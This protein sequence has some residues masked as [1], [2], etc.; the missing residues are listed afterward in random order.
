MLQECNY[1]PNSYPQSRMTSQTCDSLHPFSA[2]FLCRRVPRLLR[3]VP[4]G[5]CCLLR[6]A[7]N[8]ALETWAELIGSTLEDRRQLPWRP[9]PG[10]CCGHS[11]RPSPLPETLCGYSWNTLKVHRVVEI[12]GNA[13]LGLKTRCGAEI[14]RNK[15][16]VSPGRRYRD[17]QKR[18][19]GTPGQREHVARN[20]LRGFLKARCR[21]PLK[22][23]TGCHNGIEELRNFT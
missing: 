6:V 7:T 13:L 10:P 9:T 15:L 17:P 2:H 4:P 5:S 23:S 14:S 21:D 11:E 16:R 19:A 3:K 20:K 8:S 22:P 1:L 12:Y 18:V